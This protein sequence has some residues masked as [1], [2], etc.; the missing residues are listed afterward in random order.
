MD[1]ADLTTYIQLLQQTIEQQ[2]EMIVQ[3]NAALVRQQEQTDGK[4][5]ELCKDLV[6][7]FLRILGP[8]AGAVPT[9]P[10]D[11]DNQS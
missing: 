11:H 7:E 1:S 8:R 5:F 3:Q 9:W 6:G 2:K 10:K 4:K